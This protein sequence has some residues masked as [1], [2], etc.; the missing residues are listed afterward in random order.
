MVEGRNSG[1]SLVYKISL[2]YEILLEEFI[3]ASLKKANQLLP[4]AFQNLLKLS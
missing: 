2:I 4:L 3:I 1:M